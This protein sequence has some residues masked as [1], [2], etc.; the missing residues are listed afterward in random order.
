MRK[1][2]ILLVGDKTLPSTQGGAIE[3][4]V[5]NIID[6]NEIERAYELTI[7]TKA[8]KESIRLEKNYSYSRFIHCNSNI[9]LDKLY[10][11]VV[12]FFRIFFKIELV[13]PFNKMIA[14]LYLKYNHLLFYTTQ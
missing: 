2:C 1:I 8:N 13:A 11:K 5:Q 7:L 6:V 4:L 14:Y 9:I 12:G 3:T 10:W